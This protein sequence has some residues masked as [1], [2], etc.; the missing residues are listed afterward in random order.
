MFV[1]SQYYATVE[2]RILALQKKWFFADQIVG[3]PD[4][5]M[6]GVSVAEIKRRPD[7]SEQTL[8]CWMKSA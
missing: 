1:F 7:N 6:A 5:A 4:R 3:V 2:L 8:F